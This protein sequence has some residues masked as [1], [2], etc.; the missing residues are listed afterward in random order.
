MR[1]HPIRLFLAIIVL[2]CNF[3]ARA[4]TNIVW[5]DEFNGTSLDATKWA[6]DTDNGFWVPN[7]GYWVPGWGNNELEYY[8]SRTQNVFVT[9]GFLHI[10]AQSESYDG[11][12]YTS[13]RI[14]TT[15]LFSKRYGRFE[16]RAQ[17]PAG[18]GLWPALW[19]LSQSTNYGGWP[20]TGEIDVME[21]NGATPTQEGGTIH[22][23]GANGNDVYT[24]Q[25]Y[26]FPGGDS[27]TNFHTYALTWTSNSIAWSVDGV[28]YQTQT[29][30]WSNVGTSSGTYPYPAPFDQPFYILM[31]LAIGGNYLGNPP[32]NQINAS[33]P[34][35]FIVDYVRVYD[36]TAPLAIT[37]VKQTNGTLTLSWP[38][39]IVCHL[40]TKTGLA[41]N[42]PWTDLTGVTNP[43]VIFPNQTNVAAFYRLSS[44]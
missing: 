13:G 27:V 16:F 28:V 6:Y 8:T 32:T 12:N 33:L 30:W 35:D 20:N 9:N 31:N 37:T 10:H 17:L 42:L 22:Y 41:T 5:S 19:M 39:N 21:N 4:D 40:Q 38:A 26:Y 34:G 25:T 18:T 29:N 43:S 15:G 2:A 7:P 14:K 23:G 44:P 1:L 11:Y 24:G 3:S 36:Q